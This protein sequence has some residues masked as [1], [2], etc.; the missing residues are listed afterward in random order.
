MG[1]IVQ[2][3]KQPWWRVSC[4]GSQGGLEAERLPSRGQLDSPGDR[5]LIHLTG[6]MPMG[7][8]L[9][10]EAPLHTST[11]SPQEAVCRL[12][13]SVWLRS[14]FCPGVTSGQS[15]SSPTGRQYWTGWVRC[16]VAAGL[17]SKTDPGRVLRHSEK[18]PELPQWHWTSEDLQSCSWVLITEPHM[19]PKILDQL[20]EISTLQADGDF[21]RARLS[22]VQTQSFVFRPVILKSSLQLP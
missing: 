10:S 9:V 5:S 3:F 1:P 7:P 14:Y 16:W 15:R 19:T 6:A 13:F 21:L 8:M 18:S 2:D 11:K 17:G 4:C 20:L 22:Q 12:K